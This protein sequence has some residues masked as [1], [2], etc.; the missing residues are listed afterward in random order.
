MFRTIIAMAVL[1]AQIVL[2]TEPILFTSQSPEPTPYQSL[3]I[4]LFQDLFD[5]LTANLIAPLI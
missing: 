5:T 2:A 4:V 3:N 1:T